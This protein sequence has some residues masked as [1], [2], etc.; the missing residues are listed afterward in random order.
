MQEALKLNITT[1]NEFSNKIIGLIEKSKKDI[2]QVINSQMVMTYWNIGKEIFL[3]EQKG[4]ERAEYGKE[5][6]DTLSTVLTEKYGK[7]FSSSNLKR[8]RKFYT[9]FNNEKISATVSH[10]FSWSHF[11][12]FIKIDDSIKREFYLT[13]CANEGWSI[14]TLKE[15]INSMLFE[16]TAI[17]KKPEETILKDLALLSQN[18]EM[19]E[20]LFIKD[21]YILD[22][23]ELKDSYSEK[24]LESAILRELQSFMLEFGSDFAFLSRQKR[25][26]IGEK[27][28]YLDLLFY[29][30]KMKRLVLIELKLGTFEPQYKGQVELYLKYLNKYERQEGEQEPIALILCASKENEEI[31]LLGLDNGNIRVSEYWLNLPPKELLEEKLH[32]A[33]ENARRSGVIEGE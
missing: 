26:Q 19:S 10:Q 33:I 1:N 23:L 12:E 32:K 24:D 9:I 20:N 25:I 17:S 22:F 4:Q 29:H 6:I 8:M 28:Y 18:K 27:D 5:V 2:V 31:E 7:G 16:R 3:E 30:R 14:R 13:M 11:V 21:P 15:R